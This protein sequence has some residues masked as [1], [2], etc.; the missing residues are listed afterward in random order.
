MANLVRALRRMLVAAAWLLAGVCGSASV[1]TAAPPTER[2]NIVV[3]LADDL[4]WGGVGYHGSF[5]HTPHI[6]RLASQGVQLTNFY[7]SPMCSPTRVGL[8][9]GCYPMRLGLGRSVIRPWASFGLPPEQQTLPEVLATA[10]YR[11]RGAFGKWHLGHL[12]PAWH[13]LSQG[14]TTFRGQ[15]N[16]AADYWTRIRDGEVD[17]HK[18]AEPLDES[19][20]TTDLI[21]AAA[22]AFI[23][24]HAD[25]EPFFCYVPFTAPHDPFQAPESY[26]ARYPSTAPAGEDA[27]ARDRRT[28]AA[29]V[30]CMDDAIGRILQTL[31][32]RGIAERTLVWF[33]SD[34]GGLTRLGLNGP[35]REGKL[36]VYEGG[37]RVPCAVWWPGVIEGGRRIDVPVINLDILPTLS[38]LA[39][40]S[41]PARV[42]GLDISPL[43]TG[44]AAS[45]P[46]R[47]LYFFTG[48]AG[49][50]REEIAIRSAG[51]WKLV[52]IGPDIRGPRAYRTPQH[53]V[54]LFRVSEDPYERHDVAADHPDLVE[55]LGTKLIAF[56]TSEPAEAL[57]P[58]KAPPAGFKPPRHWRNHPVTEPAARP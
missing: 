35:L 39:G 47:D 54:E 37:V 25:R 50:Q 27:V 30:T 53:R 24:E 32:D 31:H 2:P 19:G 22:C 7:V 8:M 23:A 49:L 33:F 52:V 41:V 57:S 5:V 20:Y 13:P 48:Q 1:V 45:V 36:T 10:G 15:Y 38:R 58:T 3:I 40:A 43:L 29:M 44:R 16:G 55:K 6:D 9:T 18:D 34:N 14:F 26:L 17:W 4:G 56:R 11:H 21:A 46:Q 51:G 42:D 12:K 28:L